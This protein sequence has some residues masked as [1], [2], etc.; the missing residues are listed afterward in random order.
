[1]PHYRTLAVVDWE[2]ICARSAIRFIDPTRP[3]AEVIDAI[4]G[5]DRLVTEAL[6]GAI[7]AD[8]F[9]V[10]WLRVCCHGRE[11]EGAEVSEFK[12]TDWGN[13]LGV[14]V[15]AESFVTI[16][17]PP[18]SLIKRAAVHPVQALRQSLLGF[19]LRRVADSARFRLSDRAAIACAVDRIDGH[20]QR[21]GSELGA[22]AA[23]TTT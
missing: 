2:K 6:H 13:S 11:Y 1:M 8:L 23:C 18:R 3:V 5:V 19:A 7:V 12:W 17:L 21:L 22:T 4:S 16:S 15:A 9:R 14:E 10:P 20:V